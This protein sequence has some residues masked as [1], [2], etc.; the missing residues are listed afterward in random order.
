ML[1]ERIHD[2]LDI[3]H[4]QD[5]SGTNLNVDLLV[6]VADDDPAAPAMQNLQCQT[7][8]I[9]EPVDLSQGGRSG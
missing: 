1:L 8:P 7:K 2:D 4:A 3:F 9:R 6:T 5:S